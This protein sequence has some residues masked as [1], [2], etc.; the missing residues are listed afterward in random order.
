M[1]I[2]AV[3]I[4]V[5]YRHPTDP[6]LAWTG[7]GKQP[8]WVMDMLAQGWNLQ[9]LLANQGDTLKRPGRRIQASRPQVSPPQSVDPR[10]GVLF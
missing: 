3:V 10:Q 1:K 8:R 2:G 9:D 5:K 4:K 6:Y 7:R